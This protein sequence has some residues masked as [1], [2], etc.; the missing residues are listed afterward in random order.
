MNS[1]KLAVQVIIYCL[2]LLILA[3]GVAFAIGSNLGISPVNSV[4][5]AAHLA[6]GI[7]VGTAVTIFFLLLIGF[8]VLILRRNFKPIEL[9]QIIFATIFGFF[10][11]LTV[12][13]LGDFAIPTYA[14]QL[15]MLAISIVLIAIGVSM[16]L[17]AK[18]ISLPPEGILL[19]F[20]QKYPKYTFARCKVVFDCGLV[21]IAV[22]ITLLS[23]RGVYGVREGTVISAILLGR[24][25]YYARRIVVYLLGKTRFYKIISNEGSEKRDP[26]EP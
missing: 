5:F 10:V 25:I 7:N 1:K 24:A 14:G 12:F 9:T 11:D 26:Q 15:A 6:S 20:I 22:A 21:L 13:I 3:F 23:L 4:P 17:E 2:G 16:Y 19:A 8:Q 18:L